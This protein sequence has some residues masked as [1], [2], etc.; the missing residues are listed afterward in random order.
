MNSYRL[1]RALWG[2]KIDAEA[3]VKCTS[4]V[5]NVCPTTGQYVSEALPVPKAS[6]KTVISA[7]LMYRGGNAFIKSLAKQYRVKG[8]LTD[9]QLDAARVWVEKGELCIAQG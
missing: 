3:L 7:I 9:C 5:R 8:S 4:E 1:N 6:P 2:T